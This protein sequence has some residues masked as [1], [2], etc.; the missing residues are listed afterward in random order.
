VSL[1]VLLSPFT[2]KGVEFR[3]RIVS[4]SHAPGYGEN[5]MPGERYQRY[6]EEKARGGIALTM[7]GGSSIVSPEVSAIYNQLDVGNDAIIPCFQAFARRIHRHGARLMCQIS[8]MG[9]RTSGE[10]GDWIAPVAPSSIRD[11]AHHAVPRAME[12]EDIDRIVSSY[13]DAAFRCAEGNLDGCEVFVPSHLPGQF[14]APNANFRTD[15]YGGSLENR[16]RFLRRVL[17]DIRTKTSPSFLVSLRMA[18]DESREGGPDRAECLAVARTLYEAGLYDMLNLNGIGASTTWGISR[19]I[20]GMS[21]PLGS[22]LKDVA[23]FR[24]EVGAPVIHA[25][26]IADLS[27]AAHAI[28]SGAVDLVGMTRAHMADPTIVRKLIAGQPERIRPCVGAAYCIDRIYAG[29]AAFCLHNPATGREATLPQEIVASSGPRRKVVVVGGGPA[30]LEAARVAAHR[31]HKAVLFEAGSRLGG[32]LLIASRIGWRRDLI[33]IVDWLQ[34]EVER[35]GVD[36]HYNCYADADAIIAEVPDIVIV[37]TGGTPRTPAIDGAHHAMSSWDAATQ[38]GEFESALIY[39]EDGGHAAISLAQQFATQGRKVVIATND[40]VLGRSLG[41]SSYPVYLGALAE[42]GARIV[43]DHR[44]LSI[45][46]HGNRLSATLAHEFGA[47]REEI[48][49][50]RVITE[51]GSE[52]VDQLF[53]D[54]KPLA[55]NRGVTDVDALKRGASQPWFE[56]GEDGLLLFRV[57]DAV[58]SRDLHAAMLDSL[59]LLK[60][61]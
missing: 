58:A 5:G 17:A 28:E 19:V 38:P 8:H 21:V 48:V 18:V 57:G 45:A 14:L 60:D 27:T 24:A 32:Q 13:G 10:D 15:D 50:D 33:G 61:A 34:A 31:G 29:R 12:I 41:G 25:G 43:T 11:P 35:L 55:R 44:L 49:V 22:Y 40:R 59:R 2:V 26:R 23:A 47:A 56:D 7:F 6:H 51:L 4:T 16:M 42:A 53:H 20:G 30:G 1:D 54:L 36:I 37:A 9:R 46:K 3:N 39:D 52:P